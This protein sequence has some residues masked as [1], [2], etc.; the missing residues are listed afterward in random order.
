MPPRR[1]GGQAPVASGV[2][3]KRSPPVAPAAAAPAAAAGAGAGAIAP[4]AAGATAV[5]TPA[6]SNNG[7]HG[8]KRGRIAVSEDL[9]AD[10]S[11]SSLSD[12][13]AHESDDDQDEQPPLIRFLKAEHADFLTFFGFLI[14]SSDDG[15]LAP[16]EVHKLALSHVPAVARIT[17]LIDEYRQHQAGPGWVEALMGDCETMISK[18]AYTGNLRADRMMMDEAFN[19]AITGFWDSEMKK[20]VAHDIPKLGLKWVSAQNMKVRWQPSALQINRDTVDYVLE[21]AYRGG[22]RLAAVVSYFEDDGK[23]LM[24]L[25]LS[26]AHLAAWHLTL[27]IPVKLTS[28]MAKCTVP[29]GGHR[30]SGRVRHHMVATY[31]LESILGAGKKPIGDHYLLSIEVE[32]K[33]FIDPV[34]KPQEVK[35]R[36]FWIKLKVPLIIHAAVF[37]FNKLP[38]CD[39]AAP[40]AAASS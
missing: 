28:V 22:P 17:A 15:H 14:T 37:A 8:S 12:R 34:N 25:R 27:H 5:S 33:R 6:A 29:L 10:V 9:F 38:T 7:S 21:N 23:I 18:F 20:I 19:T 36:E 32:S 16:A 13:A 4:A 2:K 35:A 26:D 31:Q 40:A 39:V 30:T 1:A 11:Y 24:K 3:R